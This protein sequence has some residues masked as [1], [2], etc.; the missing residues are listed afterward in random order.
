MALSSYILILCMIMDAAVLAL[1]THPIAPHCNHTSILH[2]IC[3]GSCYRFPNGTYIGC[4][5]HC[6]CIVQ[7]RFGRPSTREGYC[8]PPPVGK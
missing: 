3:R 6:L 5:R 2:R 4:R 1:D 8:W 7:S